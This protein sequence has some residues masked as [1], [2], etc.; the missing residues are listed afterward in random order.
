MKN[1]CIVSYIFL[2]VIILLLSACNAVKHVNEGEHLLKKNTIIVNDKKNI[3]DEV[4]TYLIQRPN[5]LVLG[6]PVSLNFYNLGSKNFLHPYEVWKDSFPNR[7]KSFSK[8]FSEKQS[9]GYRNFKNSI[10]E[11][12]FK[13]GEAP[14][15]LDTLKTVET[16]KNLRDYFQSEGFFQATVDYKETFRTK[17]RVTVEYN[18]K[19]G[20]AYKID[21]ITRN[22]RTPILDSIYE[23]NSN[24]SLIKKG[25]QFRFKDFENEADRLTSI[26][27]N[28]GIYHF[29]RNTIHFEADSSLAPFRANVH[30]N[31]NNRIIEENDSIYSTP[32]RVQK[33]SKIDVYTDYS[34]SRKD[35]PYEATDSYNKYTFHAHDEIKYN[36]KLLTNSIFIYPDSIYKDVDRDLTR[37]NLRGLKNFRLVDIKYTELNQDSLAAQIFLTPYKKYSFAVNTEL[38]HSNIKQMGVSGKVSIMNRNIFRGAEILNFSLQGSFFNSTDVADQDKNIFFNAWEFGGDVSLEIPRILFPI[39]TTR[40][41][42]KSMSPK[43]NF[44]LGTSFQKNIGLDKQLFT[45]IIGYNWQSSKKIRHR[46][47]LINAQ[48][49]K[50]LNPESYFEIYTS[51]Y[52]DLI[53]VSE[54]MSETITIPPEMYDDNGNLIP[55]DFIDYMLDP[56]NNF[57]TSHPEEYG[58]TENIDSKYNIITENVLVPAITYEFTYNNRED[59]KDTDFSFFRVRLASAG[60]LTTQFAKETPESSNKELF[61]I[62][63]AQYLKGDFEYKKFWGM[64]DENTL[65][66]RAFLGI[67]VPYGNS[68]T[69]PFNRSYFIGGAND[70]RAWK[71]YDLGPGSTEN[72]LEYNVGTLKFLTS[73]EYRFNILN[74]FKGAIFADAG[75][76]WDI[77]NS[78]LIEEEGKF[79][80]ISSLT[81]IALGTGFGVRYDFNFLVVRLDLGFKTYEPY[82]AEGKKWFT[83]YNFNHS[84]FNFGINYPF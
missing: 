30:L 73:L 21:S 67:A 43:T 77:T 14:V 59:Y 33:I 20:E 16:A 61:G 47:E 32:F 34:F 57:E 76:I 36:S 52:N 55:L 41:I 48:F 17:K 26:Y 8:A 4:N 28:S 49:I 18:V 9:R 74:S 13:S 27:R 66:Y 51:E 42:P 50:N 11:W 45:G 84:V 63:I 39:N 40:I 75:N 71:I 68:S 6:I 60:A 22:I 79:T 3:D 83:N 54:S 70:L 1:N 64:G 81:D 31:I 5:S 80:G 82:L 38:S 78:E 7:H 53:D 19:T 15:L 37:K 65:A 56:S 44:T 2:G 29:N 12:F 10:N 58:D 25:N 62:P 35:D 23:K 72:D 46:F 69:I 24:A